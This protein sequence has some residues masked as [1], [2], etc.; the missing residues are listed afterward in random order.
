MNPLVVT[1]L[2]K[3][4]VRVRPATYLV[5]ADDGTTLVGFGEPGVNDSTQ[6]RLY[7]RQ[8]RPLTPLLSID[9][10]LVAERGTAHG[11]VGQATRS[12][13]M[14]RHTLNQWVTLNRAGRVHPVADQPDRSAR[15]RPS[16][17]GDLHLEGNGIR[18]SLAYRPATDTVFKKPRPPWDTVGHSGCVDTDGIC[19]GKRGP[20]AERTIHVSLNEGG[21]YT[22]IPVGDIVPASS[23]PRLQSCD[24]GAER[25][26]VGTGGVCSCWLHTLDRTGTQ[27]LSSRWLGDLLDP[28]NW[29]ML[30]DGRLVTGTNRAGLMVAT[31]NTN[32]SMAYRPGPIPVGFGVDIVDDR[33][34]ACAGEVW[35]SRR[36][37]G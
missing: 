20:L 4:Y 21:T 32:T 8:W 14:G 25:I 33:L 26:L 22:T 19:A 13:R 6:Y 29:G 7:D 16:R 17:P 30:P 28:Y 27:L 31:D 5:R 23:G 12:N 36:T 15:A 9:A 24:A 18:G 1:Q 35:T 34:S 3:P 11:F 37:R 2:P 10:R